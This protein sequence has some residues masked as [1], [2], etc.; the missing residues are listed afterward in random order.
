MELGRAETAY[1]DGR[2]GRDWTVNPFTLPIYCR[3]GSILFALM[4]QPSIL[5]ASAVFYPRI[6]YI[7]RTRDQL[8]RKPRNEVQ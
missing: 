2:I 3:A 8:R 1:A 5:S 7:A 4:L 6:A